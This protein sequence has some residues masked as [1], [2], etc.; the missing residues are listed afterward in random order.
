MLRQHQEP[1]GSAIETIAVRADGIEFPAT[2]LP[3]LWG[4]SSE[5]GYAAIIRD[6]SVRKALEREREHARTFLD[7]VVANLPAML[8]VRMS[9]LALILWSTM[10]GKRSSDAVHQT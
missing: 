2:L 9:T 8:F 1:T 3:S 4:H 6:I 5:Q 7:S 10:P